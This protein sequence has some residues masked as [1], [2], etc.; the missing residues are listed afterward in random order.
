MVKPTGA[1]DNGT[2]T[3]I[4]PA[5]NRKGEGGSRSRNGSAEL[6]HGTEELARER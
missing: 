6:W 1:E 2:E 3:K 4:A 5:I